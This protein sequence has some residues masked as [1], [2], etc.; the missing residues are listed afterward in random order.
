M[1]DICEGKESQSSS[2]SGALNVEEHLGPSSSDS[3]TDEEVEKIA[4]RMSDE[5]DEALPQRTNVQGEVPQF[6]FARAGPGGKPITDVDRALK[7]R[8]RREARLPVHPDH[9]IPAWDEE[10]ARYLQQNWDKQYESCR[11]FGPIWRQ[12]YQTSSEQGWPDI[13]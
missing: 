9:P 2:S 1:E 6:E 7:K 8:D 3:D 11:E 5:D 10:C 12:I 4:Q 13:S